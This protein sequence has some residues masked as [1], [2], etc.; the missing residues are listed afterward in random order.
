MIQQEY[1]IV[2][3]IFLLLALVYKTYELDLSGLWTADPSSLSSS[4]LTSITFYIGER[5]SGIA[6][7][8][9]GGYLY[10][11]N[12]KKEVIEDT[13]VDVTLR[14]TPTPGIVSMWL[15]GST[16]IPERTQVVF[17]RKRN[18]I[19]IS[20]SGVIYASLYKDNIL[21]DHARSTPPVKREP[22]IP[23]S[24]SEKAP[25]NQRKTMYSDPQTS[26]E[27]ADSGARDDAFDGDWLTDMAAEELGLG[28]R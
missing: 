17:D 11:V 26:Q 24:R 12:N 15:S 21:T 20:K 4:G 8:K 9:Y 23:A 5:I 10:I 18:H 14:K 1:L 2:V 16:I 3:I 25:L 19:T 22:M 28:N 6:D 7:K 27:P 13:R